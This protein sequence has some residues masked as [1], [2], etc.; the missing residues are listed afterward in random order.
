[1][2]SSTQSVSF[3]SEINTTSEDLSSIADLPNMSVRGQDTF[4]DCY[5]AEYMSPLPT[6]M[7]LHLFGGKLDGSSATDIIQSCYEEVVHWRCN[8]FKVPTG[9][10]GNQFV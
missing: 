8:I 10:A 7:S 9:K 6:C 1:M 3:D 5:N 2:Y 4:L